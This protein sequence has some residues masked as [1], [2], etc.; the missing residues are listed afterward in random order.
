M[1]KLRCFQISFFF[2]KLKSKNSKFMFFEH[3]CHDYLS[4]SENMF[5]GRPNI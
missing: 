1:Q 3:A 2:V 4:A 5:K